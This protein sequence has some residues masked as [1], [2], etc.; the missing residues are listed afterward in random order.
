M[1]VSYH[2]LSEY[3]DLSGITPE[4]L[5]E[6]LTLSGV[7]VDIVERRNKGVENVVVGYVT[8]REKHPDADK[9]SVCR[10]DVGGEEL[11][12]V[13]GAPNVAAGQKVPVALVGAKLPGGVKIKRSKLRGVESQG[14]ICSARELGIEDRLLPKEIQEGILVLPPELEVGQ[15]VV[16]LLGLDDA[17]LE[18][19]LTPNRS[20]CLSMLGVA[21]E[22]AA[23][24]E[25]EVRLPQVDTNVEKSLTDWRVKIEAKEACYD[26]AARYIRGVKVAPSPLWLQNRLIAAGI[27]PISNIVDVTNYVMLEYGQPLHA[28][29]ANKIGSNEIV[30]RLAKAGEKII[31]LDDV[32]RQLAEEMLLI[33]NGS[34]AIAVAGVMGGAN[35]EVSHETQDILLESAYFSGLSVRKTSKQLGLRSEASMRFEK[36]VDPNRIIP[37]L[38]RAAALIAQIAGGE[39]I[40]GI[41]RDQAGLVPH[42]RKIS[43]TAEKVNKVLGTS[44]SQ[45]EIIQVFRR[46]RFDYRVDQEEIIISVPSRRPDISIEADLIEEVARIVGYDR[47][48]VTLPKGEDI[49]GGLTPSQKMRRAIKHYLESAGFYQ[50]ITYTLTQ[51]KYEGIFAPLEGE[52]KAIPVAMP[53]SEERSVLRTN[54]LPSLLQA[55]VYNANRNIEDIALFELGKVFKS[56]EE[57]LSR[58]P[59]ESFY[60]AGIA[61]GKLHPANWGSKGIESDF[62]VVKGVLENLFEL[63]GISEVD[64]IADEIKGLHP[65]RAARIRVSGTEI[66]YLGQLHPEVEKQFDLKRCIVF[67]L[68]LD[69]ILTEEMKPVEYRFLPRFPAIRRDLALVVDEG[70]T[71]SELMQTIRSQAGDWLEQIDIFDVYQGEHIA[72]GKKSIAFSLLYRHPE[73]TLTD[74]EV[75]SSQD[76]ILQ[77]V[78]ETYQAEIRS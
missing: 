14:M 20:D 39:V 15:D 44:L 40:E 35:S 71:A 51:E 36:G 78:K 6:K 50:A 60:L 61:T 70:V 65:G 47:I 63:L 28:F 74:E 75:E 12:I 38:N 67:Q 19:D 33:T 55:A 59:R 24:L 57:K 72:A 46:L 32:E 7:A 1:L 77:T 11:Q 23:I 45:E 62:F 66:G 54:L 68:N 49:P 27:R 13:C 53:M 31:T 29:D 22:V 17:V 30:V 25:R 48:P 10:V 2:W 21:Y 41:A 42:E 18:L 16:P 76:K 34:D 4:E 43:I 8:Q 9:L 56:E 58:L 73:R 52:T 26:Y 64:Y 5:A 3:V 37:A 69:S